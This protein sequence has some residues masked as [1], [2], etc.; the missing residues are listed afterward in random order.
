MELDEE[1]ITKLEQ[2]NEENIETQSSYVSVM[3][4]NI[5]VSCDEDGDCTLTIECGITAPDMPIHE[6]EEETEEILWYWIEEITGKKLIDGFDWE[7]EDT[8]FDRRTKNQ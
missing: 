2:V 7:R 5:N 3:V 6:I 1:T 8:V 4:N